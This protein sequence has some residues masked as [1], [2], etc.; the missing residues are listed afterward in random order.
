MEPGER[1]R[2][3]DFTSEKKCL[4][5]V[6]QFNAVVVLTGYGSKGMYRDL[7]PKW[8]E[9]T[10]FE[11]QYFLRFCKNMNDSYG[12]GQWLVVYGGDPFQEE[13][14]D[15]AWVAKH[16]QQKWGAHLLAIQ[17]Q[18]AIQYGGVDDHVE[19]VYY[20]NTDKWE[21]P[22]YGIDKEQVVWGGF[23]PKQQTVGRQR[24]I[25]GQTRVDL[26]RKMIRLIQ[27]RGGRAHKGGVLTVGGG[28]VAEQ[29]CL[30]AYE[31]N[32]PV[33]FVPAAAKY[34]HKSEY[35]YPV[36]FDNDVQI[37]DEHDPNKPL[38]KAYAR[39]SRD[40]GQSCVSYD[41]FHNKMDQADKASYKVLRGAKVDG[42]KSYGP[43]MD[44]FFS[45]QF[46]D[47]AALCIA[48]GA[49]SPYSL[50]ES[51]DIT[52]QAVTLTAHGER[53]LEQLFEQHA[54][55]AWKYCQEKHPV[56]MSI[57]HYMLAVIEDALGYGHA[58]KQSIGRLQVQLREVAAGLR[59]DHWIDQIPLEELAKIVVR[60]E[61]LAGSL[62]AHSEFWAEN[63]SKGKEKLDKLMTK[64]DSMTKDQN[65]WMIRNESLS[66]ANSHEMYR[67]SAVLQTDQADGP[68][69]NKAA[70]I[71]V[72]PEQVCYSVRR[73]ALPGEILKPPS[74]WGH[75]LNYD[76]PKGGYPARGD[77]FVKDQQVVVG[78]TLVDMNK[79]HQALVEI[80]PN[81]EHRVQLSIKSFE[82]LR[83]CYTDKPE[84][85]RQDKKNQ[86]ESRLDLE[87]CNVLLY[88]L[89]LGDQ[90]PAALAYLLGIRKKK[91]QNLRSLR[92]NIVFYGSRENPIPYQ[93]FG[94]VFRPA[95]YISFEPQNLSTP[96]HRASSLLGA[97]ALAAQ[98][99][100]ARFEDNLFLEHLEDNLYCK[101]EPVFCTC[102]VSAEDDAQATQRH[103]LAM[104]ISVED[105]WV[106]SEVQFTSGYSV[107]QEAGMQRPLALESVEEFKESLVGVLGEAH[108]KEQIGNLSQADQEILDHESLNAGISK[109]DAYYK[110]LY[111]I[112]TKHKRSIK[113]S[114]GLSWHVAHPR[115]MV[116][117]KQLTPGLL[118]AS[119]K[120][121]DER[122]LMSEQKIDFACRNADN[123]EEIFFRE[124]TWGG[125]GTQ[126]FGLGD[127]VLA[128]IQPL[129]EDSS[130][131]SERT[132]IVI[133][134]DDQKRYLT[135]T[136]QSHKFLKTYRTHSGK[137]P[138]Q[139]ANLSRFTAEASG[140]ASQVNE[141][142][143]YNVALVGHVSGKSGAKQKHRLESD[144]YADDLITFDATK[145]G[146]E[147]TTEL[148]TGQLSNW[149]DYSRT[150]NCDWMTIGRLRG[151]VDAAVEGARSIAQQLSA[152]K[153]ARESILSFGKDGLDQQEIADAYY[154]LVLKLVQSYMNL[155][156][157]FTEDEIERIVGYEHWELK[158]KELCQPY[159][160]A[161][162]SMLRFLAKQLLKMS[163]EHADLKK[164]L[165]SKVE[166]LEEME[167]GILSPSTP[168][169]EMGVSVSAFD[170][171]GSS[172]YRQSEELVRRHTET[173][174]IPSPHKVAAL[175]NVMLPYFV[176]QSDIARALAMAYVEAGHE[177]SVLQ[178]RFRIAAARVYHAHEVATADHAHEP[179]YA[180]QQVFIKR[181]ITRTLRKKNDK[182][183]E[184]NQTKGGLTTSLLKKEKKKIRDQ[185]DAKVVHIFKNA[186][187]WI[188]RF[189]DDTR[190]AI[191]VYADVKALNAAA[192]PALYFAI[193]MAIFQ[194]LQLGRSFVSMC[195]SISPDTL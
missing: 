106:L 193:G 158:L 112:L 78:E 46:R 4:E 139:K 49:E 92:D 31:N 116:L 33:M 134:Q 147:L 177:F 10:L 32:V 67:Q 171:I 99:R 149:L 195:T 188:R 18:H 1:R 166:H 22:Q 191:A 13:C 128:D 159:K 144:L 79:L 26:G 3:N 183:N 153:T 9:G 182:Y 81:T 160:S 172:I 74:E 37:E 111:A 117:A 103:L 124:E 59:D 50:G 169:D 115:G 39:Y 194:Q 170:D 88:D 95:L 19:Y 77:E 72:G 53:Q 15:V 21:D 133:Q 162:K 45:L 66:K 150:V 70:V 168:D 142:K 61:Q 178:S 35:V 5:L 65:F 51:R 14:P 181:Y 185:A 137:K 129:A 114:S 119:I 64:Y 98:E 173:G 146:S 145:Q 63:L 94:D 148:A 11:S 100:D 2:I 192:S 118:D 161:Y 102:P 155:A 189:Y 93:L 152:L 107:N 48:G 86:L 164:L 69:D 136:M 123:K 12:E 6:S 28:P 131:G 156:Q 125:Q 176:A 127:W 40:D 43:L 96:R 30:H 91:E 8:G 84:M 113:S 82:N 7:G 41:Y 62:T 121:W 52:V 76:G 57:G 83:E 60:V 180:M 44:L 90:V 87:D 157:A 68:A 38:R 135:R 80:F 34:P 56:E 186:L 24:E 23:D 54:A 42:L 25:M 174:E 85:S 151:E 130:E 141:M 187:I 20:Y 108:L 140:F 89:T 29:E 17:C 184:E 36:H 105:P 101:F 143:L 110:R 126:E 58:S 122:T 16:L 109:E 175:V 104:E 75:C 55:P 190:N 97:P 27:A 167:F 163:L 132:R 71:Y 165:E 154:R 120:Y 73:P 179:K 47:E 138:P